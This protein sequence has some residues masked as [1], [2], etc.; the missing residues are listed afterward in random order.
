MKA[1]RVLL[2]VAFFVLGSEVAAQSVLSG[3]VIDARSRAV[4]P[5]AN[6]LL[7][8]TQKG[9][10]TDGDG[11]FRITDIQPGLYN[12]LVS[13]V[14]YKTQ[15]IFEIQV[16]TTKVPFIQV[17]LIRTD[18]ELDVVEVRSQQIDRTTETPLSLRSIGEAEILR[19]PGGNRDISK[20]IQ[21]LPGVASTVSFRNDIIIRG[22][23]P[24]ENSFYLDG[25]E[26]PVI[27]HFATQGA[28]GG[29]VGMIN[30]N[31]VDGVDVLSGAF[32][33]NRGNA[34]SS[35][36]EFRQ[37]EGNREKM[38]YAFVVGSSDIGFTADGPTGENSSLI[39]S[40]RRSY[41]QFLFELIGLP[42][43]P[44]YN[45]FQFKETIR[46]KNDDKL[47]LLGLAAYDVFVL[48]LNANEGVS[49]SATIETN[50]YL[51]G[52]LPEQVQWNYTVG[53]R[54]DHFRENSLH[55]FI[56]S[57]SQLS[58]SAD[59]FLNNDES[60]AQNRL[61]DYDSGE[62]ENKFRYEGK[63]YRKDWSLIGG[64]ALEHTLYTTDTFTKRTIRG[65]ST[66]LTYSSRLSFVQYAPFIQLSRTHTKWSWS[67]GVRT[68]FTSISNSSSLNDPLDQLSPRVSAS[69]RVNDAIAINFNM[70][71]YYQLP[72]FT[73]LGFRDDSGALVNVD[74]G[75]RHIQVDHLVLGVE[76]GTK[77]NA[78]FSVEGFYKAYD[79]YPLLTDNG[80]SL[81]NLG[82]DFGVIGNE[83]AL[84]TSEGRAYGVELL[85]QQ[86]L[87]KDFYGI[88]AY[89]F[90]KSE[91]TNASGAFAPSSW[92]FGHI[93][94][95]TAGKRLK[96][97]WEIGA[98]FRLQGAGPYTPFDIPTSSLIS[99]WDDNQMGLPDYSRTN[100]LRT[101]TFHQM[102]LRVDKRYYFDKWSL[103]LY[104]DIQNVYAATTPTVPF[105]N[106]RTNDQGTPI[107]DPND[108]TRYLTQLVPDQNGTVLPSIGLIVDF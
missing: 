30:V 15:T 99:V 48:N 21:A 65:M 4:L 32:P 22:G 14:G 80:V 88:L 107:V 36:F 79:H 90:V 24:N 101:G 43:L 37:K 60:T 104:L 16:G 42:F 81:A 55:R 58:N 83:P 103:N 38:N 64:M 20:V 2:I 69:Y 9:A 26:V 94:N 33:A 10:T 1:E 105:L 70:G 25:I 86:K 52:N 8:G 63:W 78:K 17:E 54:Y 61:L 28:S 75:I 40:A 98:K 39:I 31:F 56:L 95:L 82:G 5:F 96:R 51:L 85:A 93:L 67:L 53:A 19:N 23:S 102:D 6:V 47:T 84:A 41:L 46:F 44:T 72:P 12:L 71:R 76:Y 73:T 11:T 50:D 34:L 68:D 97:N 92:D 13:S 106:V 66:D 45:D 7:E 18:M 89:T 59:K 29:P 74:N 77:N 108:P 87:W 57:R 3:Q 62:T 91:F 27:N 100:T 35:V 49:D